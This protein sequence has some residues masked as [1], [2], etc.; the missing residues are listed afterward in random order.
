MPELDINKIKKFLPHRY[1]FLLIDRVLD[2]D[3]NKSLVA[4]KNVTFNEPCFQGH[5]PNNPVFPGVLVIEA[6]AQASALLEFAS[7]DEIPEEGSKLYYLVGVDKTR[8]RNTVHP[9]DQMELN[10][11]FLKFRG[12]IWRFTVLATVGEKPIAAAEIMTTVVDA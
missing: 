8:F 9:G 2:Y 3:P 11:K 5:F 6:M 1:P 4:I 7:A 10:V 12:G